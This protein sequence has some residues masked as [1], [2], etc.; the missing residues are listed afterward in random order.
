MEKISE[1]LTHRQLNLGD[2]DVTHPSSVVNIQNFLLPYNAKAIAVKSATTKHSDAHPG[3]LKTTTI[4]TKLP[5]VC[6]TESF[7]YWVPR[8]SNRS[9]NL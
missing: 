7:V 8:G 9:M 3:N 1:Y 2:A 4:T 6:N 5:E